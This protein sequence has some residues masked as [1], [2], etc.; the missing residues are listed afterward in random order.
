MRD[1]LTQGFGQHLSLVTNHQKTSRQA[2]QGR[3]PTR[4]KRLAARRLRTTERDRQLIP[5]PSATEFLIASELP[6]V[7][8]AGMLRRCGKQR[9]LHGFAGARSRFSQQPLRTGKFPDLQPAPLRGLG[10]RMQW[11]GDNDQFVLQPGNDNDVLRMTGPLDESDVGFEVAHRGDHIQRIADLQLEAG[12]R[13]AFPKA[14]Q[15]RRQNVIANRGAGK[16]MQLDGQRLRVRQEGASRLCAPSNTASAIGSNA[17]P[18]SFSRSRFPTRSKNRAPRTRSNS[19][20]AALAADCDS[21]TDN[22]AAVVLPLK[23]MARNICNWR[24]LKPHRS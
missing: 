9:L 7:I 17:R 4:V 16:N 19:F 20:S 5:K 15:Q 22:A 12:G 11:R 18:L 6:S 14:R 3:S 10:Q 21:G 2:R 24:R 23:A 1:E 13:N 8:E